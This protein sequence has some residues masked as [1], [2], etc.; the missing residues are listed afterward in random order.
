[1]YAC[2]VELYSSMSIFVIVIHSLSVVFGCDL[3]L[4]FKK[5]ENF[6]LKPFSEREMC[7][8]ND[9][10]HIQNST[11]P[12]QCQSCSLRQLCIFQHSKNSRSLLNMSVRRIKMEM[13]DIQV[14]FCAAGIN[15]FIFL[16][17]SSKR[18]FCMNISWVWRNSW[19]FSF[20][21]LET[22]TIVSSSSAFGWWLFSQMYNPTV[23]L[24]IF[25]GNLSRRL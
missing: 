20:I 7:T 9:A 11:S 18:A 12:A 4:E 16:T 14:W 2:A 21:R 15:S 10:S 19:I 1:M 3:N 25:F 17:I 22:W 23:V 6:W 8:R 5:N 13:S 24:P